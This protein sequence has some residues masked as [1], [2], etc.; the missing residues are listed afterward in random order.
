MMRV[1]IGYDPAETEAAEVC[2]KSLR[3]VTQGQLEPEFLRLPKLAAQ[4]LITRPFDY[5]GG[6]IYDLVSNDTASTQFKI[7]RFLVPLL[8]QSG[9]A[10]FLDCD[11]LL[12]PT[13]ARY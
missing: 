12:P 7:T 9:Y 11:M 6:Q 10:L 3:F 1:Y 4:G 13:R 5:R 8:C 2:A